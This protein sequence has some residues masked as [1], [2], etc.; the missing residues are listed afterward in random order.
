MEETNKPEQAE[1]TEPATWESLGLSEK[2]L[3]L[4][5]KA[6]FKAPTPIQAKAI[7]LALDGY[8]LIAS[9]QTGTGKT[10]SFVL[11]LIE[12][13]DG[14][15][16]TLGLILA[17]TREIAQQI[18]ATLEIFATP[19]GIRS[20]VLI[21]GVSMDIDKAALKDY[22]EVIVATPGR[23]CD[24][25]DRGTVWLEYIEMVILDEADRMLDMGFADQLNRIMEDV[26]KNRQTLL[27]SA[28]M[29]PS[30]DKLAR[31][32]LF[33]P[34]RVMIGKTMTAAK[35]VEQK[36]LFM[37]EESKMRELY[38]LMREE[39]GSI[40]I[41]VRSKIGADKLWRSLH[42]NG[43]YDA[44]CIHSDRLQSLREQALAEFKEGK[45][46]VL[47]ATDVVGRGIHVDDVAHVVNYDLPL[48]AEDYVHRVGR[49]GRQD[50]TG[51]ATS[52]VTPNDRRLLRDIERILKKAIPTE[53]LDGLS[54]EGGSSDRSGGGGRHGGGR[55]GGR[56]R[57]QQPQQQGGAPRSLPTVKANAAGD[58]QSESPQSNQ[59]LA[60][61]NAQAPGSEPNR[62]DKGDGQKRRR[63]RGGRGRR[64]RGGTGSSQG[65]T[66]ATGSENRSG[67]GA[68]SSGSGSQE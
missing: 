25:L 60:D 33:E 19:Q 9:A 39:K 49:T 34:E 10:A 45:Y 54:P 37:R 27:F 51:K 35:T 41:F 17:P 26:P 14:R 66:A 11:P 5:N 1:P 56:S 48:E 61:A 13:I 58:T 31:K 64:G 2:T 62:S 38:R 28:T 40:I 43:V 23:L 57:P 29:P 55:S 6:G 63:R 42:S 24:H 47:I 20:V 44:T 15:R 21:G 18:Q 4:I 32:I 16:G 30:V 52:F 3:E 46:R 8:D 12:K 50:A 7:P 22:P 53:Y 65:S 67:G 68:S 59:S 36:L